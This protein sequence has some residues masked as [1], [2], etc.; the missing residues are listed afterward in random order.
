MTVATARETPDLPAP[1]AVSE[2]AD[3]FGVLSD[4]GR[5]TLLITLL[6]AGE[7]CVHD[8]A[9]A[10]G[11]SESAVSHALRLLRAHRVVH[12]RKAGRM[13]FYRLADSHVRQLL[14]LGLQHIGHSS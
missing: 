8:L 7:L 12:V 3:I 11:M 6:D 1:E 4:P 5:L 10:A 14:D 13:S 9:A 2:L